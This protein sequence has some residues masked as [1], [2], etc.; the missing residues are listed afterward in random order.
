MEINEGIPEYTDAFLEGQDILYAEYNDIDFFIEDTGK[1]LFYYNIFHQL[2]PDIKLEKIFPLNGKTHVIR[3]ALDNIGN[4]KKVYIVDLDFDN[5]LG[6]RVDSD[7]LF[8][9]DRY[10]IENYLYS[11][12]SINNVI[13]NSY[14]KL[15]EANIAKI[16]NLAIVLSQI[17]DILIE[18]SCSFVIIRKHSLGIAYFPLNTERDIDF[19]MGQIQGK[20]NAI[21]DYIKGVKI[22]LN[23]KD[24]RYSYDKQCKQYRDFFLDTSLIPGKYVLNIIS[25]YLK[26]NRL[27]KQMSLTDF[28]FALS[29]N[30]DTDDFEPLRLSINSYIRN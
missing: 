30:I 12:T 27:I 29:K 11:A 24:K 10:S 13:I 6:Q 9:L 1:E 21:G 28:A 2:F 18:L 4:K 22:S 8:Y 17:K 5:I 7:N 3:S 19:R 15:N 20:G 14:P 16:F 23:L 26:K 25:S